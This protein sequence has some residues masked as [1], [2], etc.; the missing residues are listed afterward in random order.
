M[1]SRFMS[2]TNFWQSFRVGVAPTALMVLLV[3][4]L[5]VAPLLG[6]CR[7]RT[8][9]MIAMPKQQTIGAPGMPQ[10]S[11]PAIAIRCLAAC[12]RHLVHTLDTLPSCYRR[13]ELAACLDLSFGDSVTEEVAAYISGQSGLPWSQNTWLGHGHTLPAD[14]FERHTSGRMPFVIF[15]DRNPAVS[16]PTL[17]PFRDDPVSVLWMIPISERERDFAVRN[18]SAALFERLFSQE[19]TAL[20]S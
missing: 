4:A 19:P 7:T 8:S 16:A 11:G 6:N 17:P 3:I 18:G 1:Q 2:A 5:E 14:V 15:S 9:A 10:N 20:I 13:I 12:N